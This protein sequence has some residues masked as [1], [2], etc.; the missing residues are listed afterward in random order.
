MIALSLRSRRVM[1]KLSP[2]VQDMNEEN[3]RALE[4]ARTA[5]YGFMTADHQDGTANVS[6]QENVTYEKV[7]ASENEAVPNRRG[8]R[9][10][11]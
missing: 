9:I 7:T 1:L 11:F 10:H 5:A 2:S 6:R 4:K 3:T 8:A